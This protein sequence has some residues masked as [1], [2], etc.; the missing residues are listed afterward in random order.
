MARQCEQQPTPD[1][2]GLHRALLPV[3]ALRILVIH[4]SGSRQS[5]RLSLSKAN[6]FDK[7]KIIA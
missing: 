2:H 1:L 3:F 7:V 6:A 4:G 5:A